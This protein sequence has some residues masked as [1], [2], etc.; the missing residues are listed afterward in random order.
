KDAK[1]SV[2]GKGHPLIAAPRSII[3]STAT[4]VFFSSNSHMDNPVSL[5]LRITL[6]ISVKF[7]DSLVIS[8]SQY[9]FSLCLK[10]AAK[11]ITFSIWCFFLFNYILILTFILNDYIIIT[12]G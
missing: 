5:A 11:L 1:K 6:S 9:F 2:L 10:I 12:K 8:S 4:L 7:R 3:W